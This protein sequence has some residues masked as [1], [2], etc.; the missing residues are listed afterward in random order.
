MLSEILTLSKGYRLHTVV[1]RL[2]QVI[3]NLTNWYIRFNRKRLKGGG[4][5][6]LGDTTVALNTLLE[7]LF[8]IVRAM[9]PFTPFITEHI[10]GLLKPH[11]GD[12]SRFEDSR[13]VHF[14]PFP[15]VQESL[16]DEEVE[17]KLSSM[18]KAIRL[19]RTARDHCNVTLKIPLL[20]LVVIADPHIISDIESLKT[21]ILEELNVREIIATSNEKQ[22]NILLEAK[23]DWPTLGKKLKK[24]VKVVRDA[25]PQLSQEELRRYL[26]EKKI[27][28]G[29]IELGENDLTIVRVLGN[30]GSS[31]NERSKWGSAFVD[32][33]IVLVDATICPELT[34]EGLARDIISRM[35]KLRKKAGLTPTDD[36]LMQYSVLNNP[37]EVDVETLISSREPLF[38]QSLRGPL[39]HVQYAASAD[40]LIMEEEQAI[41]D[42]TLLLRLVKI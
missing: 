15:S 26:Q 14:L 35:Q 31:T 25:L 41:G 27:T 37:E 29:G 8:T 34:E 40:S 2:L 38:V 39:E 42:L 22:F 10:Y 17:R 4:S 5:L 12:L 13:S 23:V 16:F 21:Y 19:G 24:D 36:I 1:P 7:V 3:D 18:Q 11:L 30:N 6:G 28:V 33:M 9:A 32:D 20:S